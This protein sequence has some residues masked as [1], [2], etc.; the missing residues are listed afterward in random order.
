MPRGR[1][2]YDL[3]D[4]IAARWRATLAGSGSS[5][6]PHW[7][8]RVTHY[9]AVVD[10][11][12]NAQGGPI[13]WRD[14]VAAIGPR[15]SAST[16]YDVAGRHAKNRLIDAYGNANDA[17]SLQ[18]ALEYHRTAAIDNLID[19]TK[20]WSFWEYREAYLRTYR[21]ADPLPVE[22]YLTTLAT[23]ASTHPLLA[24]ALD[25]APP[26]CA[27]ED[28]VALHRGGLAALRA[29]RLLTDVVR[30]AVLRSDPS[31]PNRPAGSSVTP[32][33]ARTAAPSPSLASR[34]SA[35]RSPAA[36]EAH[37]TGCAM[38]PAPVGS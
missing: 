29:R 4:T 15:G 9:R 38:T 5:S 6:R 24:A 7:A 17:N 28:L 3:H 36:D 25:C 19:E 1:S 23:W 33:P 16:F 27:V 12:A 34:R 35:E 2:F 37:R 11:L 30:E 10:A 13:T 8:T 14:V 31:P 20:T 18:I 22:R 21:D 32:V 26:M